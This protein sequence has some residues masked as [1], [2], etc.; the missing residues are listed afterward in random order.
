LVGARL[1]ARLGGVR[2]SVDR[3]LQRNA[4][5]SHL[6]GEDRRDEDCGDS[7]NH[8]QGAGDTALARQ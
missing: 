6:N 5:D 3:G 7:A 2:P 8:R 4:V 1:V